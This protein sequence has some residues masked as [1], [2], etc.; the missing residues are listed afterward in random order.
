MCA[1]C[2]RCFRPEETCYCKY[3]KPV[4]SGIKFVFLMHPKEAY[5]QK[6]GT[7]RLA[8]LSLPGSEIII[9][10]DFTE[11]RRLKELL[12]DEQYYPVVMY[13]GPDAWT[14]AG[15]REE[16]PHTLKEAV[17]D[18]TLLVILV[19]ATWPC[20]RKMLRLSPNVTSLQK[21]SFTAGY[22]SEY[23]FKTEPK[24]DYL[25]TIETCYYLLR[26]LNE[27]EFCTCDPEPLMDVFRRMVK[28]QLECQAERIASGQPDRYQ[29]A[30]GIR[31]RRREAREA[32]AREAE[33][34][35]AR[36]AAAATEAAFRR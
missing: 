16:A 9:G 15:V 34:Q 32:A 27:A 26:E 7:G 33:A 18:K 10:I 13:P 5:K 20:A 24:P 6:T 22:S 31:A 4:E 17:G 19:D 35:K 2:L 21:I 28:T 12:S 14:A 29:M 1:K 23:T 8:C 30:G 25:S 11:N 3:I 36:E